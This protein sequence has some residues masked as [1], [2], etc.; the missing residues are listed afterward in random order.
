[1]RPVH[2]FY[3]N[4]SEVSLYNYSCGMA[5]RMMTLLSQ[6]SSKVVGVEQEIKVCTNRAVLIEL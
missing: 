2:S 6:K 3:V 1:V 5:K 4:M